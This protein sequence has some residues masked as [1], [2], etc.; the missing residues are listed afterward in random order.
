MINFNKLNSIGEENDEEAINFKEVEC[1]SCHKTV[2]VELKPFGTKGG[3]VASCPNC[4]KLAY[5]GE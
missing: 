5:N 2:K 1:L 3:Y 4:G